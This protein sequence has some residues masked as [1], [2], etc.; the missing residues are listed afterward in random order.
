MCRIEVVE[1]VVPSHSL[2]HSLT[3]T[4]DLPPKLLGLWPPFFPSTKFISV[5]TNPEEVGRDLLLLL[6]LLLL[7][8]VTYNQVRPLR[9]NYLASSHR[10][11]IN[12]NIV[13]LLVLSIKLV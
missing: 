7:A 10:G 9:I 1:G 12:L 2:T 6:L 11:K 13:A 4:I 3:T 8:Q 5:R